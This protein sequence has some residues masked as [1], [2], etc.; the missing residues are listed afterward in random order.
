MF[1]IPGLRILAFPCNQFGGG[2]KCG[3]EGI[4]TTMEKYNLQFPFFS[5]IDCNGKDEHPL[6][7][8]LKSKLAGFIT[9]SVKWNFSKFLCDR[10]GYPVKRYGPMTKPL[11]IQQ[12]IQRQLESST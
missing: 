12:D 4:K 8:F 10:N 2:E 11:S 5:I 6:F 7:T 1:C 9:N 3:S